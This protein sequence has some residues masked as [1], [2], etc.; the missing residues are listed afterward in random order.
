MVTKKHFAIWK[1]Q[2]IRYCQPVL[3]PCTT[4]RNCVHNDSCHAISY[5]HYLAQST[6]SIPKTRLAYEHSV[7]NIRGQYTTA[8][9]ILQ[10]Q[11]DK[12][13]QN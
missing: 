6:K 5:H 9:K 1:L 4:I 13:Q 8:T 10:I 2:Q 12:S 3:P 11:I 7:A